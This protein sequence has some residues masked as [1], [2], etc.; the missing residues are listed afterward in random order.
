MTTFETQ[1]DLDKFIELI[2]LQPDDCE[3]KVQFLTELENGE[4][5]VG[6]QHMTEFKGIKL[7]NKNQFTTR[8]SKEYCPEIGNT[9]LVKEILG[10]GKGDYRGT[11]ETFL[12]EETNEYGD[13]FE[14]WTVKPLNNSELKKGRYDTPYNQLGQ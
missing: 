5:K 3:F 2:N 4:I 10:N 14:I 11:L 12:N 6:R 13:T 1:T 9:V 7:D 8:V